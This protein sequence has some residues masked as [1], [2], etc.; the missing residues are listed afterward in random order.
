[1]KQLEKIVQSKV[2]PLLDVAMHQ[3]LGITINELGTDISDRLQQSA[4]LEYNIDTSLPFK[5]AKK[6]FKRQYVAKLLQL[7]FGNV[8]DVARIAKIDRRSIH[9]L[10]AE[11]KIEVEQ[12]REQMERNYVKE[13]AVQDIIQSALEGYK[14]ALNPTKYEALYKEAPALSKN[15]AK[16]LPESPKTLKDAEREFEQEYLAQVLKS[17]DHNIS[18]TARKIGLRFETLHRKLKSLGIKT[19]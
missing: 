4:L 2:K 6:K 16:E 10:I 17:N 19:Q 1:M 8:A 15:I 18:K 11:A 3:K 12:F 14:D 13:L 7:S 5:E 9:R